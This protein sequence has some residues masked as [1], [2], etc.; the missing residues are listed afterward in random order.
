MM[1]EEDDLSAGATEATVESPDVPTEDTEAAPPVPTRPSLML[2]AQKLTD[3]CR[4]YR[5]PILLIAS[6]VAS[7]GLALGL[8]VFQYRPDRQVDDDAAAQAVR[9]ASDG[10]VSLLSYSSDSLDRDLAE[11]KTH[12]TGDFLTYYTKFTAEVVTPA[13]REKHLTQ[14]AVVVRAA[15]SQLRPESAI[16]LAYV[17]ET[18]TGAD[19]KNPLTTPS[20]VR[21]TLEKVGGTWLIS[22]LDPVG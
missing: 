6:V 7:A 10:A 5:R 14:K 1:V 13:V 22:K 3:R 21:V 12:L 17:N 19:K 9:A 16:V 15:A 8:F 4:T 11:A 20:V 2:A 18:V